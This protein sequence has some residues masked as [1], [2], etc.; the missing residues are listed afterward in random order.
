MV[1]NRMAAFRLLAVVAIVAAAGWCFLVALTALLVAIAEES[2]A[3][4]LI[5][6]TFGVV[7]TG[8]VVAVFRLWR[9]R[10][11]GDSTPRRDRLSGGLFLLV[12]GLSLF[13]SFVCWAWWYAE[14]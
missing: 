8:L 5:G 3:H 12:F 2:G 11:E 13:V 14:S 10:T 1:M 9:R 7:G 6:L 4:A